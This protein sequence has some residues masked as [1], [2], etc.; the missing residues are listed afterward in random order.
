MN[1][2]ILVTDFGLSDHYVGVLHSVLVRDAPAAARID[3]CHRIAPGDVWAACHLLRC[4]W[5]HLPAGAVVMAV[6]DPGVGGHRRPLA[7]RCRGHW[8]VAPDN[9]LAAAPGPADGAISLD[10][11]AM[12]LDE[13]SRTFHGRDL[14]A[15]AAAR[16]ARGDDPL[17][18]GSEVSASDVVAC[19]IPEPVRAGDRWQATVVHVDRFGNL[20]TNLRAD[21]VSGGSAELVKPARTARRVATYDDGGHDELILLEGSS[22]LLELAVRRGSA[23]GLTRLGRGDAVVISNGDPP[24]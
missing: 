17:H 24:D 15:P 22:G 6:V 8:L 13:P 11:R 21:Q 19:P 14:F 23:A 12:D 9:G 20:V 10:W 16:I 3:L 1:P 4:A 7:L 2:I 5:E 18:L